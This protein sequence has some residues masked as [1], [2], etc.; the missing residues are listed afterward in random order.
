[1]NDIY[2]IILVSVL[3]IILFFFLVFYND[4]MF[5]FKNLGN[6]SIKTTPSDCP[7]YWIKYSKHRDSPTGDEKYGCYID[8]KINPD[9][10]YN[11]GKCNYIN[12]QRTNFGTM[13]NYCDVNQIT[14]TSDSL[15]N[16]LTT[17]T[18]G[19][20]LVDGWQSFFK[21]INLPAVISIAPQHN[22]IWNPGVT[23]GYDAADAETSAN[24]KLFISSVQ[25][26]KYTD[27]SFVTA[28]NNI[29]FT[30]D[31]GE[32]TLNAAQAY[33]GPSY[34]IT[35]IQAVKDN[36]YPIY[37]DNALTYTSLSGTI[38]YTADKALLGDINEYSMN[39][40]SCGITDPTDNTKQIP[41]PST[42]RCEV[43]DLEVDTSYVLFYV[44]KYNNDGGFSNMPYIVSVYDK[45]T[46]SLITKAVSEHVSSITFYNTITI[47]AGAGATP[48]TL[49][50]TAESTHTNAFIGYLTFRSHP[51]HPK[52]NISNTVAG[53]DM[54]VFDNLS[55]CQKRTWAVKND[56][57]WSGITDNPTLSENCNE[58]DFFSPVDF[59]VDFTYSNTEIG[60]CITKTIDQAKDHCYLPTFKFTLSHSASRG[61]S[62]PSVS[63][64][65]YYFYRKDP[66]D[67]ATT[68]SSH[69]Y[70]KVTN[71]GAADIDLTDELIDLADFLSDCSNGYITHHDSGL[72]MGDSIIYNFADYKTYYGHDHT[73]Y[74]SN[75]NDASNDASFVNLIDFINSFG[76][77]DSTHANAVY[78]NGNGGYTVY[79]PSSVANYQ[80]NSCSFCTIS[81]QGTSNLNLSNIF[82]I[83]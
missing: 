62:W 21:N 71:P 55:L 46:T 3:L 83:N 58:D 77:L 26:Y 1:M 28:T 53:Y 54:Q 70:F 61:Q 22:K 37:L 14:N 34:T 45:L 20:E 74:S 51:Y 65:D 52:T 80:S 35:G 69:G 15:I 32:I 47:Q 40:H 25:L 7:D 50:S 12:G 75:Q 59:N 76:R 31:G 48:T 38:Q 41:C 49:H 4:I 27:A 42:W 57:K 17:A 78:S 67:P 66:A 63:G 16:N 2:I 23:S 18:S 29:N 9:V 82:D 60:S 72:D 56:I 36:S 6:I 8:A 11:G 43:D 19:I 44:G 5:F 13:P 64:V 10:V 73:Y 79:A 30:V 24:D 81:Q 39:A 68:E 33:T